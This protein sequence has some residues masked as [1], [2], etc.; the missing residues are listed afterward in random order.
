MVKI[1]VV[2]DEEDI[3]ELTERLLL[4]N[5]YEVSVAKDG[6]EALMQL[7]QSDVDLVI[8][9]VMMPN[10]HGLDVIREMKSNKDMKNIPIMIFSALG[11]GTR[12]MLEEKHQADGYI[13]KPFRAKDFLKQIKKIL[14]A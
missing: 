8:L 13:Q 9:D 5:G 1:L 2:D 12:L 14:T 10:M 4:T 7:G 6:V 11:T 3:L